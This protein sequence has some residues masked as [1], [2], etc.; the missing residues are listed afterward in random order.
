MGCPD[1]SEMGRAWKVMDK[2]VQAEE[3]CLRRKT[4]QQEE[5]TTG[6]GA[7]GE[8]SIRDHTAPGR[9]HFPSA[10]QFPGAWQ[11]C[12]SCLRAL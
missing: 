5:N 6:E 4:Q 2:P 12:A 9:P 11:A 1:D 3:A 10:E 7:E 8:T